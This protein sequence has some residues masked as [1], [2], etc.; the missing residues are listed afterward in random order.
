MLAQHD[1]SLLHGVIN[2][3]AES[4]RVETRWL[5]SVF[6]CRQTMALMLALFL[7][8]PTFPW[9]REFSYSLVLCVSSVLWLFSP[10]LLPVQLAFILQAHARPQFSAS[11]FLMIPFLMSFALILALGK[12]QVILLFTVSLQLVK[13]CVSNVT[14]CKCQNNLSTKKKPHYSGHSWN[15]APHPHTHPQ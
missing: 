2:M 12:N 8:F 11:S 10:T 13:E 1:H 5:W 14:I 9:G 4:N 15:S 7:L 6:S 3:P